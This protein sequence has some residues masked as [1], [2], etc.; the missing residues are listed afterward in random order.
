MSMIIETGDAT[1][2]K[3]IKKSS[4]K[5]KAIGRSAIDKTAIKTSVA[6]KKAIRKEAVGKAAT[7][8][9][10]NTEASRAK[11]DP[12]RLARARS[13]AMG[14]PVNVWKKGRKYHWGVMIDGERFGGSTGKTDI[15]EAIA[16]AQAEKSKLLAERDAALASIPKNDMYIDD[17]AEAWWELFGATYRKTGERPP[18]QAAFR[19]MRRTIEA[20]GPLTLASEMT[21]A[22]FFKVR[23]ELLE[24]PPPK[25][26]RGR[27]RGKGMKPGAVNHLLA[28]AMKLL[29]FIKS[30]FPEVDLAGMPDPS[31][32][33]LYL[34]VQPRF[35]Y[36]NE[37]E[38]RLFAEGCED[39]EEPDLWDAVEFDNV[40]GMRSKELFDLRWGDLDWSAGK[41][42]MTFSVKAAGHDDRP[43]TVFLNRKA[44]SILDRR[45]A[46]GVFH[47]VYVFTTRAKA[48]YWRDSDKICNG[49]RVKW[50][51]NRY[52]DDFA[53]VAF[54]AGLEDLG[55]HDCRRTAA[56]RAWLAAGIEIAQALLGHKDRQT[57]LDYIGISE[58]DV[59]AAR[60]ALQADH[61]RSEAE[62][63]AATARGKKASATSGAGRDEDILPDDGNPRVPVL[64]PVR[65]ERIAAEYA[66]RKRVAEKRRAAAEAEKQREDAARVRETAA[67][68]AETRS[69]KM[70]ARARARMPLPVK[71]KAAPPSK[72]DSARPSH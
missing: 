66:R 32:D 44:L 10:A 13:Q 15:D 27:P 12:Y 70:A 61:A 24:A 55:P 36:M 51:H 47:D 20:F 8:I 58:E 7:A 65:V 30:T 53:R 59:I 72:R 48:T 16:Y 40:T 63:K 4:I 49:D 45:R 3:A 54:Y 2:K 21:K 11:T 42:S 9:T 50:I 52:G 67:R 71:K 22:Y 68:R 41:E 34:A 38:E 46:E 57:T 18:D 69:E 5:N 28:G 35:N 25:N 6:A 64:A 26:K 17:A 43:H 33:K 39:L 56:R 60:E 23:A 37:I 29:Y 62:F 19:E 14:A 31:R 1:G